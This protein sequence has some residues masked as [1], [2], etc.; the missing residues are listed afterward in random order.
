M[1]EPLLMN[2]IRGSRAGVSAAGQ[3]A[4]GDRWKTEVWETWNTTLASRFPFAKSQVDASVVEFAEFFR[5]QTGVLWGFF[6][7]EL[8]DRLIV[9]GNAFVPKDSADPAQFRPDF[10]QCLAYA[11]AITKAVFGTAPEPMV[12]FTVNVLPAGGNISEITLV[13]DGKAIVYR[14][15]PERWQAARWPGTGTTAGGTLKVK[16]AGFSEQLPHDGEFGFFRLLAAG[17]LKQAGP[18]KPGV[19]VGSWNLSR[20]GTPPVTIEF[21]PTKSSHPFPPNFFRRLRCPAAMLSAGP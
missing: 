16:G 10:L 5:P 11:Q 2:P 19:V 9:S 13:I 3:A 20:A 7:R 21:K 18:E 12:P 1:L 8:K 15:E 6:E 14:N 17:G 4:L